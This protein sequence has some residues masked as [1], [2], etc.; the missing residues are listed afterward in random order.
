VKQGGGDH[1]LAGKLLVGK[2]VRDRVCK[3]IRGTALKDVEHRR[4]LAKRGIETI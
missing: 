3:L 4:Q 1:E 2:S